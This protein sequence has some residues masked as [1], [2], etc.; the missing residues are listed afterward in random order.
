[1]IYDSILGTIGNTP[2]VR[3]NRLAPAAHDDLREV[4]GLQPDELR[5]GPPRDRDDRG[6]REAGR[7]EAGPDGRRA[8]LG[9][10]GHRARDGVRGQGLPV[11]R[12]HVG[13]VLGR[14]PEAHEGPRRQGDPPS[15]GRA[16]NR[17]GEEGQGAGRQA[18]LVP[19]AA[20]REPVQPR[21]SPP[22]DRARDPA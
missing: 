12:D 3:I 20:V 5:E 13:L 1:M 17:D 10:H 22:D 15:R 2:V 8:D 21:L 19:A 6:R 7:P 4:R 16:R 14:A 11:R 18:R 9:Q